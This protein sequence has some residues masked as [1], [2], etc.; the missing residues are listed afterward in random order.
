[1]KSAKPYTFTRPWSA[2]AAEPESA[3]A[4]ATSAATASSVGF[5]SLAAAA[6]SCGVDASAV[7]SEFCLSGDGLCVCSVAELL[8]IPASGVPD[9]EGSPE[10]EVDSEVFGVSGRGAVS[11]PVS[12]GACACETFEA[13]VTSKRLLAHA[14]ERPCKVRRMLYEVVMTMGSFLLTCRGLE[15]GRPYLPRGSKH[16]RGNNYPGW[17]CSPVCST[18]IPSVRNSLPRSLRNQRW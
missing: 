14:A 13:S 11:L 1:M 6:F 2:S 15:P 5:W 17:M 8:G 4:A 12:E 7:V 10:A 9:F 18:S 16:N 3:V